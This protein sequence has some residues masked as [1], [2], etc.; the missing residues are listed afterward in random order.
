MS[1]AEI[2]SELP[3]LTPEERAEI[4]ESLWQLE[5]AGGPTERERTILNEAQAD[6]DADPSAGSTWREVETRLRKQL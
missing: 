6:Y 5:E 1:K 4:L 2:L 3:R